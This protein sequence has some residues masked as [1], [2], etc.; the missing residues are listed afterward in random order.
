MLIEMIK[1]ASGCDDGINMATYQ[2]GQTYEISQDL[3][4]CFITSGVGKLVTE[5]KAIDAAPLNKALDATNYENKSIKTK[6]NKG[7]DK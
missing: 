1:T 6:T 3:A 2:A 4:H 7:A 5:Q